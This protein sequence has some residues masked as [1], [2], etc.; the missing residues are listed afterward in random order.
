MISPPPGAMIPR[1]TTATWHLFLFSQISNH[2]SAANQRPQL[3]FAPMVQQP[4]KCLDSTGQRDLTSASFHD[5]TD[6][7]PPRVS[8]VSKFTGSRMNFTCPCTENSNWVVFGDN[9]GYVSE[10]RLRTPHALM[11]LRIRLA[12]G[13]LDV[14]TR[15]N[16]LTTHPP[17]V[18]LP[19]LFGV[20][21]NGFLA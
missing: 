11:W 18:C 5:F 1:P 15:C 3:G 19:D 2:P 13:G 9:V 6:Q 4:P 20:S 21:W 10:W 16:R 14:G 7:Q 8:V 17:P 12:P